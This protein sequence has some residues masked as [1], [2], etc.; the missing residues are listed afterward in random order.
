MLPLRPAS[1]LMLL[2]ALCVDSARVVY[3]DD[4]P[5]AAVRFRSRCCLF[6]MFFLRQVRMSSPRLLLIATGL[7]AF[8]LLRP[9][10]VALGRM[11]STSTRKKERES[12]QR[13]R[14][15]YT[16]GRSHRTCPGRCKGL[17]RVYKKNQRVDAEWLVLMETKKTSGIPHNAVFQ[18]SHDHMGAH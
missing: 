11:C 5:A 12:K 16:D 6:L 10:G 14:H 4:D 8:V 17:D 15:P 1:V 2:S 7:H 13:R 9:V 3:L 18:R